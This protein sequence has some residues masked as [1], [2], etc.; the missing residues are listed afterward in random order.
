VE[1][2]ETGSLEE[3]KVK[4]NHLQPAPSETMVVPVIRP[5]FPLLFNG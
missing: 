5:N 4:R 3:K 1:V 2:K